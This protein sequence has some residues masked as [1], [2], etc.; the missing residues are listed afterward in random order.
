MEARDKLFMTRKR[1]R[2]P[3]QGT[4]MAEF[5]SGAVDAHYHRDR[6]RAER[7]AAK[8]ARDE[9][10]RHAH[11]GLAMQ[12][13]IAMFRSGAARRDIGDE[14]LPA[15]L[16]AQLRAVIGLPEAALRETH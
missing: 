5:E 12:H 11:L 6:A 15:M 10:V 9:R 13:E 2:L 14:A 7:L 4:E 1:N 16:G 8:R 3:D